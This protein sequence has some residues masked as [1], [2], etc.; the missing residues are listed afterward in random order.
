MQIQPESAARSY[1]S[2]AAN[3]EI[4]LLRDAAVSV[5]WDPH[6]IW[7]TRIKAVYEAHLSS[8]LVACETVGSDAGSSRNNGRSAWPS[9]VRRMLAGLFFGG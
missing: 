1:P 7:R 5:G 2:E 9:S 6:E 4:L 3:E 8:N